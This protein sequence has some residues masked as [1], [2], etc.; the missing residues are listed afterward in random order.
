MIKTAT[1][2]GSFAGTVGTERPPA[3]TAMV[4]ARAKQ[5]KCEC[6]PAAHTLFL[7]L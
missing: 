7:K 6:F 2:D 3:T 4:A 1:N 5:P